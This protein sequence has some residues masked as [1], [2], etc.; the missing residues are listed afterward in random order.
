MVWSTGSMSWRADSRQGFIM[1][2]EPESA[3][4]GPFG[5]VLKSYVP[6]VFVSSTSRD[7]GSYRNLVCAE[8][9]RGGCFPVVQED[10]PSDPRKLSDFLEDSIRKADVLICLLGPRFGEGPDPQGGPLRSY[11]QLEYETARDLN[12]DVYVFLASPSCALDDATPE[13]EEKRRSQQE[14]LAKVQRRDQS[15]CDVFSGPDE[16]RAMIVRLLPVLARERQ[17]RYCV[18][19]PP[20]YAYFAGR[21]AELNQLTVAATGNELPV[22]VILGI[23]GQ[24]KTTLAWEWFD[25]Y[26][27]DVFAGTFWCPAEEN[28][29]TFDM[30]VDAALTYLSRG[31]YDKRSLPGMQQRIRT[32][33]QALCD[34]PCLLVVDGMEKWLLG[35]ARRG[36]SGERTGVVDDRAGAQEG[37]DLFLSQMC[38]V[39]GGSHLILTSRVLPSALESAPHSE[40]PVLEEV[41]NARLQGLDEAS[42]LALLRKLGVAGDADLLRSVADDFERHPLSLTILGK[43]AVRKYAGHLERMTHHQSS[44]RDDQRLGLLLDEMQSV[45]PDKGDSRHL[46][47]LLSH[48]IEIPQYDRFAAFMRWLILDKDHASLAANPRLHINDDSLREAVATLD[49][50]SLISWDRHEDSLHMHPLLREHFRSA[51]T[52]SGAIHK[53]LAEWYLMTALPEDAHEL[54]AMRARILALE[55]GVQ[56]QDTDLCDR[57]LMLPA[58]QCLSLSEWLTSWGHQTTGIDLLTKVVSLAGEPKRSTHLISRGVM[59]LHLGKLLQARDD[60]DHAIRWLGGNLVRRFT[61]RAL[62]AGAYMNRGNVLASTGLPDQAV[63]DFGRA[64][65]A[66]TA[67]LGWGRHDKGMAADILTNRGSAYRELGHLSLAEKDASEALGTYHRLQSSQTGSLHHFDERI[68]T[69]LLNRGNV[70][71]NGRQFVLAEK[72][73]LEA[74]QVLAR[75]RPVDT[76]DLPTDPLAALIREMRGLLLNDWSRWGDALQEFDIVVASL[77]RLVRQGR[78]DLRTSLGLAYANRIE[79]QLAMGRLEKAVEDAEMAQRIYE[80]SEWEENSRLAIWVAANQTT[81]KGLGRILGRTITIGPGSSGIWQDWKALSRRQGKH[82]LAPIV[83][84]TT[85]IARLAYRYDPQFSAD[86]A[87]SIIDVLV[88]GVRDGY[89]SEWLVWE[90]RDL[91]QFLSESKDTMASMGVPLERMKGLLDQMEAGVA[92]KGGGNT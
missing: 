21:E 90:A 39:T 69:T 55:H 63:A 3:C 38:S 14:H 49:D 44:I 58:A 1:T 84:A 27:P 26:C 35:W 22:V 70:R 37:L 77:D 23:A 65:G 72:D 47:D 75:E 85:G 45:L 74:L 60:L 17:P 15:K 76:D 67:P 16:L 64:L 68:A 4:A 89:S 10:F 92:R 48:F 83:R 31:K 8:L 43:I 32:L 46:M 81:L 61:H 59:R 7:L 5:R 41:A 50:W 66:L 24:G 30:F 42:A 9:R 11:T 12:K 62:L 19:S 36:Q 18:Q 25:R 2:L 51:C 40:I 79:S 88:D 34:R 33:I 56:A 53:A 87:K 28:D 52:K 71:A 57:A 13:A 29:Y 91:Q 6:R 73:Y 80:Q 54:Q 78:R 82:V 86:T 20:P